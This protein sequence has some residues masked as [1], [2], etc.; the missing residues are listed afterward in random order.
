[1]R[2]SASASIRGSPNASAKIELQALDQLAPAGVDRFEQPRAV[3]GQQDRWLAIA[4]LGQEPQQMGQQRRIGQIAP[5]GEDRAELLP[6]GALARPEPA[7]RGLTE[8]VAVER[9][10]ARV[11]CAPIRR[12]SRASWRADP[13]GGVAFAMPRSVA[14]AR[15]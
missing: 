5:P 14:R 8:R 9:C 12:S 11:S 13:D 15:R 3:L 2:S 10:A 7:E 1:M 6:V 4:D